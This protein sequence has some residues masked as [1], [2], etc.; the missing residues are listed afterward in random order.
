MGHSR[1][2]T[3][4][5]ETPTGTGAHYIVVESFNDDSNVQVIANGTVTFTVDHTVQNILFDTAAQSAVNLVQPTD[6]ERYVDPGSAIWTELI[7]SGTVSANAQ[8]ANEPVFAFRIDI[9]AGTG[10]VSY[11]IAQG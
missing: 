5:G 4:T 7:A 3:F 1:N 9:T 10:S 11:H 2:R 8:L 6:P